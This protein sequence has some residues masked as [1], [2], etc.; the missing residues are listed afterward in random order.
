MAVYNV[1]EKHRVPRVDL[2]L[3]SACDHSCGHCYNVWGAEE[4]DA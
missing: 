3:M 2:K 4:G 1:V